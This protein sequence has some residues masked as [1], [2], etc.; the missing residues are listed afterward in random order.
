MYGRISIHERHSCRTI[1]FPNRK[2]ESVLKQKFGSRTVRMSSQIEQMKIVSKGDKI[3]L[4]LFIYWHKAHIYA[5]QRSQHQRNSYVLRFLY[6]KVA[7]SIN[8]SFFF[9]IYLL[10]FMGGKPMDEVQRSRCQR[11]L[12]ILR[13]KNS[14]LT[15]KS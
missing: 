14:E 1:R 4:F 10:V 3:D 13:L 11:I 12:Q 2:F 6:V 8:F 9:L 15:Y 5:V 7:K